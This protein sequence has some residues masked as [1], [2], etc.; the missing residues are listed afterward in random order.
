[1]KLQSEPLSKLLLEEGKKTEGN[2]CRNIANNDHGSSPEG[3]LELITLITPVRRAP[4]LEMAILFG[5][6]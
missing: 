5:A 3:N 1:M 4:P 2:L 6:Y